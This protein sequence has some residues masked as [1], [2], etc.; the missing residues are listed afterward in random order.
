MLRYSDSWYDPTRK[1]SDFEDSSDNNFGKSERKTKKYEDSVSVNSNEENKNDFNE[2]E[3]S[4]EPKLSNKINTDISLAANTSKPT[5]KLDQIKKIDMG[6]ALNY[7]KQEGSSQ[8]KQSNTSL[9]DTGLSLQNS[10]KATDVKSNEDLL[11][12]IFNID[13]NSSNNNINNNN[14]IN[15]NNNNL[16][17]FADFTQFQ[18]S[19]NVN[20]SS[21]DEFAD[22]ATAFDAPVQASQ[23]ALLSDSN[24]LLMQT[25]NPF[26][27][28]DSSMAP[29][30]PSPVMT[31][32]QFPAVMSPT[33]PFNQTF[34]VQSSQ[35]TDLF[36]NIDANQR[37]DANNASVNNTWSDLSGNVNISVDNLL[38]SK[39]EKQSAPTMNQLAQGF[40]NL[41]FGPQVYTQTNNFGGGLSPVSPQR[42]ITQSFG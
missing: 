13:S 11:N 29:L 41:S 30:Q 9:F 35:P 10:N 5:K 28:N 37:S 33:I 16:E 36:S 2:S 22:F 23:N 25:S 27:H 18:S 32:N 7:G 26:I 12:E 39:Y 40:N 42:P 34:T 31:T 20:N 1:K 4:S 6:A 15:N 24:L 19:S 38:G 17:S 3:V 8:A 14:L 21:N